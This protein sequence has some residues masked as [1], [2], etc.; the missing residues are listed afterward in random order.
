MGTGLGSEVG[1]E[2]WWFLWIGVLDVLIVLPLGVSQVSE[3][4]RFQ[5]VILRVL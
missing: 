1:V 4:F 5:T 2:V 3:N